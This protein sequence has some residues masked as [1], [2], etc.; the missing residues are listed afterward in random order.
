MSVKLPPQKF[1]R[2]GSVGK[3]ENPAYK[4][5]LESGLGDMWASAIEYL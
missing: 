4:A 2:A 5:W 3:T 1:K